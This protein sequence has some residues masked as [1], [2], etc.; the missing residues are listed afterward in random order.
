MTRVLLEW[1]VKENEFSKWDRPLAVV[2]LGNAS[3]ELFLGL[4]FGL[5][6]AHGCTV[7][8]VLSFA[9][10]NRFPKVRLCNVSRRERKDSKMFL[11]G[12][13]GG[14]DSDVVVVYGKS[15]LW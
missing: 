2:F 15:F 13:G 4:S 9:Y 5:P 7:C 1:K 6:V 3:L 12:T 10:Q 11:P 14:L 8:S